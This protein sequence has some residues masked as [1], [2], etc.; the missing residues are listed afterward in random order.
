MR[1]PS[2]DW[3][4][5]AHAPAHTCLVGGSGGSVAFPAVLAHPRRVAVYTCRR[6]PCRSEK[7]TGDVCVEGTMTRRMYSS[8]SFPPCR[9]L[10][11]VLGALR[12]GAS[13]CAR[14]SEREDHATAHNTRARGRNQV[15]DRSGTSHHARKAEPLLS[16][17]TAVYTRLGA[18][19]GVDF[20]TERRPPARRGTPSHRALPRSARESFKLQST[21]RN[22][23]EA[24]P[25]GLLK[26]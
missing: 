8:G 3:T 14:I 18:R 10:L 6:A 12:V 1:P 26:V 16:T 20:W 17:V 13:E 11:E 21:I 22:R 25:E 4:L 24:E 19:S 2:G 5:G 9:S 23:R 7:S 15:Q